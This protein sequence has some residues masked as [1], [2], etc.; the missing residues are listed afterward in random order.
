MYFFCNFNE[1]RGAYTLSF[2]EI[3]F[4]NYIVMGV[5]VLITFKMYTPSII[6]QP[7]RLQINTKNLALFSLLF[8]ASKKL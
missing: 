4:Q 8:F 5:K 6:N 1:I 3:S 2:N 7:I